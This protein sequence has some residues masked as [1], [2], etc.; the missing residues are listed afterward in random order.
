MSVVYR[1][2]KGIELTHAELDNNFLELDLFRQGRLPRRISE[3]GPGTAAY[4]MFIGN[5][6]WSSISATTAKLRLWPFV[7]PSSFTANSVSVFISSTSGSG[8]SNYYLFDS[9]TNGMPRN[10]LAG[11][12]GLSMS[13]TGINSKSFL[14]PASLVAG[15]LYWLGFAC[16]PAG[17]SVRAIPPPLGCIYHTYSTSELT[18]YGFSLTVTNGGTVPDV[19]TDLL[20][21]ASNYESSSWMP[22]V[23]FQ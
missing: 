14:S 1:Q 19:L 11:S 15:K 10:K 22:A 9:D 3:S 4:D 7:A 13:Y 2:E 17:G 20:T 21:I 18:V 23:R 5:V 6:S 12:T 16:N 8:Y